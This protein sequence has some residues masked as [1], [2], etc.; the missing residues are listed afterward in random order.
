MM[1]GWGRR[2]KQLLEEFDEHVALE[3]QEN[4]DAGMSPEEA[5]RA[6]KR[7]FGNPVMMAEASREV[8]AGVWLE[9]LAQDVRYAVRQLRRTPGFA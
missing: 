6:A 3:T 1:F 2:R 4:M 9:R 5:L 7:K 8:W